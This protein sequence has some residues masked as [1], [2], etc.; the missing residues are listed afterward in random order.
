MKNKNLA[1]LIIQT[2]IF[3]AAL[4]L[5]TAGAGDK[6]VKAR[7]MIGGL[8]LILGIILLT[9]KG[10]VAKSMYEKQ[11]E[12]IKDKSSIEKFTEG[13]THGGIL[14]SFVGAIIALI[15]LIFR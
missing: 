4:L 10:T 9:F 14:L 3:T 7:M 15:G 13:L 2:I 11:I 6:I 1:A 8:F 12:V 5:F